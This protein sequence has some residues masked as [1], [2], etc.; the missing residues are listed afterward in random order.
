MLELRILPVGE[1]ATNCYLLACPH[2]DQG[3]LVD[4]G[5]DPEAVLELCEGLHIARILLTHGHFDHLL[6]LDEVRATLGA[7][8]G[9]HPADVTEF[10]VGAD[11]ELR[12]GR[13]LRV[14]RHFVRIVH[15][16]GHTPG[17]VALRFD[18]R[19]V[20][21]DALF[22]G[23]PGHTDTP[24]AL[25]AL[26]LSLQR[27]VFTWPDDTLLYPGHGDPTTVGAERPAFQEFLARARPPDLCGDVTW[28]QQDGE[29]S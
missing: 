4:P 16:P 22:P 7:R 2:V 23:G 6:G 15:V 10:G 17:S 29:A 12:N 26:L 25:Q 13:R 19:A 14:G 9:V 18:R 27:T 1:Y 21:G 5:A 3:L 11:F 24:Q 28:G 20:V 8:V